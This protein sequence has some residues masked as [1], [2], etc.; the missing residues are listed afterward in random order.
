MSSV[1]KSRPLGAL[2]ALGALVAAC[3]RAPPPSGTF[4]ADPGFVGEGGAY[5]VHLR[6]DRGAE[7][8]VRAEPQRIVALLPSHTETLFALGVGSRVVGVDDYS[9]WPPEAARLP[10]LGSLYDARLEALLSLK[11]DL[12]LVSESSGAAGPLAK[13]GLTVWAGSAR[14]FDDIFRVIDTIGQLVGRGP[15]A[16]RLSRRVGDEITAVEN[17]LRGQARVRVYYELDAT[18]YTVGPRSFIGVML[19]KA[20][21]EDIVPA[22]LGDF[23]KISPEA[24]IAGNPSIILGAS[25]DEIRA[26]PGWDKIAAVR[27]GRVYKL[28]TAEAQ[29]IARPGPRIAEGVRALARRL[30]PEVEL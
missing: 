25:L 19:A 29:L 11:P 23:P 21:G 18:P 4:A 26:R 10:K 8:S 2:L 7:V 9:D 1:A 6:D 15:E 5:P 27:V 28:P 13:S 30:H 22:D 12:V 17:R 16:T 14:T 3:T 20:G 24:V